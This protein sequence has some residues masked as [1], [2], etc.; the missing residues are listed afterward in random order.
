MKIIILNLLLSCLASICFSQDCTLFHQ[1]HCSYEDYTFF[2]SSQ[3]KSIQFR[4]G[5]TSEIEFIAYGGEEYYLAVCGSEKLGKIRFRIM[6]DNPEKTVL[7]DNADNKYVNS[8]N[9]TND[10]TKNLI[11]Q[12]SVPASTRQTNDTGC[13]GVVIQMRKIK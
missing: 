7:F 3:S 6:A 8:I 13:L 9:F 10:I 1:Y 4:K 12:I 5:Q 11:I 2:N